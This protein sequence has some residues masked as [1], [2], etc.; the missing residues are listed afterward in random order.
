MSLSRKNNSNNLLPINKGEIRSEDVR[1][2][3]QA[4]KKNE[5]KK[6][7]NNKSQQNNNENHNT[8]IQA[9]NYNKIFYIV[10]IILLDIVIVILLVSLT[11]FVNK[12]NDVNEKYQ[13]TNEKLKTVQEESDSYLFKALGYKEKADFL[14]DNIVF[15]LEGYGNVYYTY[16]CVKKITNGNSYEYWAFNPEQAIARGYK[17]AKC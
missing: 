9:I 1:L 2:N 3:K 5:I 17:E 14:D 15:V 10:L 12:Y 6:R 4:R 16:D 8:N 13:K 7:E 11:N